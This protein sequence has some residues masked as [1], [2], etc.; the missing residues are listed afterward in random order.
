MRGW[1]RGWSPGDLYCLLVRMWF[2][3]A[4]GFFGPSALALFPHWPVFWWQVTETRFGG[5]GGGRGEQNLLAHLTVGLR[6]GSGFRT[7]KT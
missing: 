1:G 6:D 3:L 5:E 2:P 7:V 4:P